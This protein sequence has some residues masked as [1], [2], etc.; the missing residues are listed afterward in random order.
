MGYPQYIRKDPKTVDI[1]GDNQGALALVKNPYLHERSK[2]I[3]IY[4]HFIRD[5]TEKARISVTYIPTGDI[6]ADRLTKPLAR[7][8][9]ERF[10][11]LLGLTDGQ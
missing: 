5:L 4:Y 11:V 3:N 8:A 9:F 2:H 6:V 7:V 10:K 1:R